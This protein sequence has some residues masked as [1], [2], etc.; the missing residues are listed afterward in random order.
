VYTRDEIDKKLG[1]K[2]DK[3]SL[4]MLS[5]MLQ[6]KPEAEDVYTKAE[7]DA[8]FALKATFAPGDAAEGFWPEDGGQW[9][10]VTVNS[11]SE[12]GGYNVSWEDGSRSDLLFDHVRKPQ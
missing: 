3:G 7:A 6:A 1:L 5:V 12:G 9:L 4:Q 11:R 10:A 2:E 8:I